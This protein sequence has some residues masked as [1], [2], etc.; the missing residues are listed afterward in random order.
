MY[1]HGFFEFQQQ[2]GGGRGGSMKWKS[3]GMGGTCDWISMAVFLQGKDK[4]VNAQ[5]H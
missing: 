4:S 3:K 2:V 1:P 5:I